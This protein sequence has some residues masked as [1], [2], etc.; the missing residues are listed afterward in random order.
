MP[1][2]RGDGRLPKE[3]G[4]DEE[5]GARTSELGEEGKQIDAAE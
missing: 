4:N 1:P 3:L 5:R 2:W